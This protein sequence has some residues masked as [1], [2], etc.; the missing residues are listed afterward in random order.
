MTQDSSNGVLT[1]ALQGGL[2][3]GSFLYLTAVPSSLEATFHHDV[4]VT[5]AHFYHLDQAASTKNISQAAFHRSTICQS[6][7]VFYSLFPASRQSPA[8]L[9]PRTL[10]VS[11]RQ[12]NHRNLYKLTS[13][14]LIS[15][16]VST[17]PIDRIH[18]TFPTLDIGP[19]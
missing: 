13:T 11:K 15:S 1:E 17:T 12:A 4:P 14:M 10:V 7:C 16:F 9:L 6:N 2:L 3:L 19:W 5:L 8:R 18:G